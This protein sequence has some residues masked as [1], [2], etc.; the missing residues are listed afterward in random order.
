[1][2]DGALLL[3]PEWVFTHH[4]HLVIRSTG[5]DRPLDLTNP[6]NDLMLPMVFVGATL[7]NIAANLSSTLSR[8]AR[9]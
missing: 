5:S 4:S 7:A 1:M 6:T 9:P 3:T 2:S 8:S